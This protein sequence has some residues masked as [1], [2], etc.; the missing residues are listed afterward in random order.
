MLLMT[1]CHFNDNYEG[2]T[3]LGIFILTALITTFSYPVDKIIEGMAGRARNFILDCYRKRF[4]ATIA[5]RKEDSRMLEYRLSALNEYQTLAATMM[6]GAKAEIMRISMDDCTA[7]DEAKSIINEGC[8][9]KYR[10]SFMIKKTVKCLFY[11]SFLDSCLSALSAL[12][13]GSYSEP[14]HKRLSREFSSEVELHKEVKALVQKAHDQTKEI[15][16]KM[17]KMD[18]SF[19]R[20][21]LLLKSFIVHHMPTLSKK[22]VAESRLFPEAEYDVS[23]SFSA[24]FLQILSVIMLPLYFFGFVL[25]IFLFGILIGDSA[26]QLWL[27]AIIISLLID[28]FVLQPFKIW[29]KWIATSSICN[30]EV[31]GLLGLLRERYH[32][33]MSRVRGSITESSALI[34]HLNPACRAARKFPQYPISRYLMSLNDFDLPVHKTRTR[35]W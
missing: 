25:Y 13:D 22:V 27:E 35:L 33:I 21:M 1:S 23:D 2:S 26:S 11:Q 32:Y 18:S 28:N 19:D 34:Q 10:F 5:D 16:E 12:F 15:L 29:V 31:R 17:E 3:Y 8:N 6:L 30:A 20:E 9:R 4:A 14:Y 24:R 7:D